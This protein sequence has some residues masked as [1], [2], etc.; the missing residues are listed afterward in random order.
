MYYYGMDFPGKE[1]QF[2]VNQVLL[3]TEKQTDR[4]YNCALFCS[5]S[6]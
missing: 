6:I 2:K 3:L 5:D 1:L 4:Q